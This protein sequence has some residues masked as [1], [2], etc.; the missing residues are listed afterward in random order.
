MRRRWFG[1]GGDFL[2][3]GS[4]VRGLGKKITRVKNI[5]NPFS[6]E[7]HPRFTF[8]TLFVLQKLSFKP[9]LNFSK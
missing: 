1:V 4:C 8:A 6:K 3:R 5:A 7:V 2:R 9:K